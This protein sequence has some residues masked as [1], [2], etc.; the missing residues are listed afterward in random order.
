MKL[1]PFSIVAA[2]LLALLVGHPFSA[3]P[4]GAQILSQ[5]RLAAVHKVDIAADVLNYLESEFCAESVCPDGAWQT[6]IVVDANSQWQVAELVLVHQGLAYAHA[7]LNAVG[8]DSQPVFAGYRVRRHAGEFYN[9]ERRYVAV[10]QHDLQ[11]INL[12]DAVFTRKEG[13]YFY[14]ELGHVV[15]RR[16]DR[17]LTLGLMAEL[18][19]GWDDLAPDGTWVRSMAREAPYELTADAFGIFLGLTYTQMTPPAYVQTPADIDYQAVAQSL[20]AALR[21]VGANAENGSLP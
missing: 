10:V 21:A 13:F 12:A 1:S 19:M 20:A 14:H 15:D 9:P 16:L 17:E 6:V 8:L 11:E 3:R 5:D 7:A 2:L 4:S 18:S